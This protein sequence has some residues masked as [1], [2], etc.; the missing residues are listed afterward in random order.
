MVYS[1]FICPF[2]EYLILLFQL[3]PTQQ[4]GIEVWSKQH[5]ELQVA[6]TLDF[7]IIALAFLCSDTINIQQDKNLY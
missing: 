4:D 5:I 3:H 7:L 6:L 2:G 1:I